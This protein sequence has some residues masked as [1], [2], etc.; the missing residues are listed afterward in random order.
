[1]SLQINLFDKFMAVEI[2]KQDT[3]LQF[4]LCELQTS[5]FLSIKVIVLELITF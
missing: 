5:P 4:E 3:L 1:M 2:E